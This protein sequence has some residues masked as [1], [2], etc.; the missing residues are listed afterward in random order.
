MTTIA[1]KHSALPVWRVEHRAA[2]TRRVDTTCVFT[3]IVSKD[4][5]RVVVGCEAACFAERGAT[6][7]T[8]LG[9]KGRE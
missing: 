1:T 2:G 8:G 7:H 5:R 4:T 3:G 9:A 6:C